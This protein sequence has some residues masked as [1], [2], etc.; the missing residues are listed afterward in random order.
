MEHNP[1]YLI[2]SL[3]FRINSTQL[4]AL[5]E[6]GME[7]IDEFMEA[8]WRETIVPFEWAKIEIVLTYKQEPGDPQECGKLLGG[9]PE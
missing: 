5:K 9:Q 7:M 3:Y 6:K 4:R 2:L 1:H 8:G